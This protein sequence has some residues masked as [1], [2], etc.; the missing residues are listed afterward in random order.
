MPA[1]RSFWFGLL[2]ACLG[3]ASPAPAMDL[4]EARAAFGEGKYEEVAGIPIAR[5]RTDPA[6]TVLCLKSLLTLGRNQEA[7]DLAQMAAMWFPGDS[8]VQLA[9]YQALGSTGDF[10]S[11]EALLKRA[12]DG[13]GAA[14]SVDSTAAQAEAMILR[15]ADPK[16]VLRDVLYPLK[17]K[18]PN[19]RAPHL[20]IGRLGLE[21]HDYKLASGAFKEG[22][23][24]FPGDP[25]MTA[26]LAR[27][28]ENPE[29]SL[30]LFDQALAKNP[31]DVG[32]LLAQAD[33]LWG[34]NQDAPAAGALQKVLS[35]NAANPDALARLAAMALLKGDAKGGG[36]Y[37][38]QALAVWDKNPRVDHAIGAMLC[39]RYRFED[40]IPYLRKAWELDPG[41]TTAGLELGSNLLRFGGDDEGWA[42]IRRVHEQDPYSV[43][44]F[45]L[46]TL[47]DQLKGYEYLKEGDT[48]LRMPPAEIAVFGSEALEVVARAKATLAKK[49]GV[50]LTSPLTVEIF[51]EQQDFAARTFSFPGGEGFL[52]VCFGPLI[53]AVSP[54]GLPGRINWQ[55]VLWH[56]VGHTITL[57]ATRYRIPRWLTEGISVYEEGEANPAWRGGM[58]AKYRRVIEQGKLTP[59][60]ALDSAFRDDMDQAYFQSALAVDFIVG[61]GGFDTLRKIL[62]DLAKDVPVNDALAA[63]LGP[64]EK[65][66]E[67]FQA[68]ALARARAYG[69]G[70]NWNTLT[71]DE[72]V[73]FTKDP[74][75]FIAAHPNRYDAVMRRARELGRQGAWDKVAPLVESVIQLEPDNHEE[76][77]PYTLLA[78]AW[79]QLG[80]IAAERAAL[81]KLVSL[82]ASAEA[83]FV[84][85]VEIALQQ[86]DPALAGKSARGVL[87]V[88]PFDPLALRTL[89]RS[90][91][92]EGRD[93]DAAA[94]YRAA[95]SL[96]PADAVKLKFELVQSLQRQ[97]DPSYRPQ[98]LEV[99][100]ENP[101]NR[102]A[103]RML[104]RTKGGG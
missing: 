13:F 34:L 49:Y 98:L 89:A 72:F 16:V 17:K 6:L 88:N 94:Y 69:P 56:E 5:R 100:E 11:G 103:L 51:G 76:A 83:A 75:A 53:T 86:D 48:Q 12:A 77:S 52:G 20:A 36:K 90:L 68:Y 4:E 59:I 104:A 43:A 25:E 46:M 29:Y 1:P 50:S 18:H 96:K 93:K 35:V 22:L 79:K 74:D 66:E 92:A 80:H 21:K 84:R 44:A 81:E 32:A 58:A 55:E 15:G 39:A 54:R 65:V 95:L 60:I 14:L 9:A 97:G 87:A 70:M 41:F 27:C 47:R 28:I 91:A 24:A 40:G 85:L 67:D 19:E 82:N 63:R 30:P 38:E 23:R 61:Q 71:D 8:A 31:R 42:I 62:A 101:R 73:E 45:N 3:T 2:A 33:V 78:T 26:G 37:R 7:Y 10:P 102:E 64:I 99:L 57:L